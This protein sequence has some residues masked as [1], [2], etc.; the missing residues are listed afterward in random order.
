[1]SQHIKDAMAFTENHTTRDMYLQR[2]A[3]DQLILFKLYETLG[4]YSDP[5]AAVNWWQ[6]LA[7]RGWS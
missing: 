4:T 7:K 1:M 3:I 5:I 6:F 2:H